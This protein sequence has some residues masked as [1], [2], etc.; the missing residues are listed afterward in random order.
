MG[1]LIYLRRRPKVLLEGAMR[2]AYHWHGLRWC[3]FRDAL[4]ST[5]EWEQP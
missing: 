2:D 4:G 3:P 1:G 5:V